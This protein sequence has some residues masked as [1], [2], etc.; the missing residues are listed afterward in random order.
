V[1]CVGAGTQAVGRRNG[2][3][4]RTNRGRG[5]GPTIFEGLQHTASLGIVMHLDPSPATIGGSTAPSL[6]SRSWLGAVAVRDG[7]LRYRVYQNCGTYRPQTPVR[8]NHFPLDLS[9][10]DPAFH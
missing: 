3:A 10:V 9:L 1:T 8:F 7:K 2:W 4:Q 5:F 6:S